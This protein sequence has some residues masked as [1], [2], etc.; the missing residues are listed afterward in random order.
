MFLYRFWSTDRRVDRR[1]FGT[2]TTNI[3]IAARTMAV[4][5][6]GRRYDAMMSAD[7][8]SGIDNA[9]WLSAATWH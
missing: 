2:C 3:G 9:I 4:A 1:I 6:N 7:D 5:P 8:R